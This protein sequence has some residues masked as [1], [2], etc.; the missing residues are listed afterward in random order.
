MTSQAVGL[1][2]AVDY[3]TGIGMDA[4]AA[5]ERTLTGCALDGLRRRAGRADRRSGEPGSAAGRC[6]SSSTACTPT[7]S[8]RC[9]TT[10]GWPCGWGTTARGRCTAGSGS[11]P[12]C[13]PSFAVYNTPDEV[14]A[15]VDGVR[16]A[17]EFFGVS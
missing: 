13:A 1:G 5:H 11:P 4:V 16:A 12:P 10:A 6:R 15:L 14:D 17:R 8:G 7:T 3:L 2:A 9:S